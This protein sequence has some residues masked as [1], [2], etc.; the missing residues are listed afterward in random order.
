MPAMIE[1]VKLNALATY[2][3]DIPPIYTPLNSP[4]LP[5]GQYTTIL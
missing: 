4:I 1:V 5:L 3:A 2:P